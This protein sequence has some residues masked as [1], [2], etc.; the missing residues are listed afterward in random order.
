MATSN[1]SVMFETS[2]KAKIEIAR[3]QEVER[4][5]YPRPIKF[6]GN[7]SN[8]KPRETFKLVKKV[9]V[10]STGACGSSRVARMSTRANVPIILECSLV[11]IVT[12]VSVM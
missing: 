11:I 6:E 10:N 3:V 8:Q 7:P 1:Y 4:A 2:L 5:K 9:K 12:L